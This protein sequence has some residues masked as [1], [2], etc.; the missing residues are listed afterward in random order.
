MK[1]ELLEGNT[2]L[3][4][5]TNAADSYSRYEHQNLFY[6]AEFCD[7]YRFWQRPQAGNANHKVTY[8]MLDDL[9]ADFKQVVP[10]KPCTVCGE[11]IFGAHAYQEHFDQNHDEDGYLIL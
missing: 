2:V 3:R 5:L 10:S 8:E 1:L 11:E 6:T 7:G 9:L 4:R